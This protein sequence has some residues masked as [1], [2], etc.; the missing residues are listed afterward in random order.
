MQFNCALPRPQPSATP[1]YILCLTTTTAIS[2]SSLHPV[3]YHDHS[4]Q[5]LLPTSCA[6]TRTQ[7]SATPPYILYLT[8]TT[9]IS[10]SFLHPVSYHDHSHQP[11]LPT[12]C[13][14]RIHT[15]TPYLCNK[16][17]NIVITYVPL[18]PSGLS[19]SSL[20]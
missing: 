14:C 20:V 1:P 2:H 10:H 18:S 9:A 16:S 12:S 15:H 6:L 17:F 4:H 13:A 5:P 3:P 8:T 19:P 7:P 11:L